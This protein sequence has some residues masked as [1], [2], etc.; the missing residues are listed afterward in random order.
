M[1]S[2]HWGPGQRDSYR[3][4]Q[5][6]STC[7]SVAVAEVSGGRGWA[8]DRRHSMPRGRPGLPDT[9]LVFMAAATNL[10]PVSVVTGAPA[11]TG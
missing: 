1:P 11:N 3:S 2:Y 10:R 6:G 5:W 9:L 4:V 7:P 8:D